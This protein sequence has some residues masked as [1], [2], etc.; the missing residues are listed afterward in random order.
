MI[1]SCSFIAPNG[2]DNE[3]HLPT[4]LTM[5]GGDEVPAR[6]GPPHRGALATAQ[7]GSRDR[8]TSWAVIRAPGRL[9]ASG[10]APPRAAPKTF[11][12]PQL[13]LVL[14]WD[15]R[16]SGVLGLPPL[17]W[18]ACGPAKH[19]GSCWA[20]QMT[21]SPVWPGTP[22]IRRHLGHFQ[23]PPQSW[24][25]CRGLQSCSAPTLCPP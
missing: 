11:Y 9:H 6:R 2:L 17:C 12:L 15:C 16:G 25:F 24:G 14:L 21:L 4:P 1:Q 18:A 23:G 13:R 22:T 8:E 10:T 5:F 20:E 3:N 19:R 7:E